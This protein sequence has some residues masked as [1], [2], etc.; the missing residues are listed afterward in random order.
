MK[1][2]IARAKVNLLLRV[3]ARR[4]D[5]YHE[6]EMVNV[7][8]DLADAVS[9]ESAPVFSFRITHDP[10]APPTEALP[11][12]RGNIA[13]RAAE[14]AARLLGRNDPV[15]ITLTKRIPIAA[16]LAGGSTDA[17]AVLRLLA[18][19]HPDLAVAALRLGAD[20][21]FCLSGAPAIVRGIGEQ[22]EP[23]RVKTPLNLVVANPGFSVSTKTVF[24]AWRSDGRSAPSDAVLR[25]TDALAAGDLDFA[26][27]STANDLQDV[28]TRLY[29]EVQTLLDRM[30]DAGAIR[31]QMSGS[32]PTVLG[33]FRSA[34]EARQAAER[35]RPSVRFVCSASLDD[36]AMHS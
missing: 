20:V 30:N 16:G 11:T 22:I 12:D 17:A 31:S 2:T 26:L 1:T 9:I 10:D 4:A 25:L 34:T 13:V 7:S 18:P 19:G 27:A 5:G 36:Q 32:G 23:I 3:L 6:L 8:L 14:E 24:E 35:L 15:R 21:P 28:T 33:F 29:P